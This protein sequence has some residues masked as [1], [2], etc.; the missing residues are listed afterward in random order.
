MDRPRGSLLVLS[1][2]SGV[3]KTTIAR[4]LAEV[5][6]VA[7]VMTA[8]TRGRRPGEVD[9]RDYRFLA[10]AEFEAA[11]AR[12]EFLEYAEIDGN[13]YGTPRAA[14]ERE[15]EAGRL[16]LV[17][18]DV[19]GARNVRAAGLPA[20][21][22]FVDPPSAEEL[23]RRLEGRRSE[24]PGAV[25]Q[26]LERAE[27]EMQQKGSYDVVVVNRAVEETVAAILAEAR[28]RKLLA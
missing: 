20:F 5:P 14:I 17:D 25:R 19:Q 12:G 23:R 6:G 26:R 9:G 27:R 16:V 4:R 7:R 22:V 15:L 21:F 11:A 18:I 8:T 13:L 10:R 28:K 24:G 2:P 3:G 1:G